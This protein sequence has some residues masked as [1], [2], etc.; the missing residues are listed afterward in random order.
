[1]ASVAGPDLARYRQWAFAFWQTDIFA[2]SSNVGSPLGL[3]VTTWSHGPG[4]LFALPLVVLGNIVDVV[5][6]PI[7]ASWAATLIF[8]WAFLRILRWS[9][10]GNLPLV[11][12]GL[13]AHVDVRL[14][15]R[16]V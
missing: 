9:A 8:W 11:A 2:I 16:Y 6:T 15:R 4:M 1:M 13:G 12:L 7:I 10:R 5:D 14:R 3:P